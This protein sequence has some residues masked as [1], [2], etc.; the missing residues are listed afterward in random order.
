VIRIASCAVLVLLPACGKQEAESTTA[1]GARARPV[2][3]TTFYPTAYFARRIGGDHVEVECPVP[4][5]EYPTFWLPSPEVIAAYQAADLVI[6]NGATYE[7]WAKAV[8]LPLAKVVETAKPFDAE[9]LRFK[10]AIV[11]SHGPHGKHSHTGVDGHT[12]M[13]PIQAKMQAGEIRKALGRLLPEA[14][15]DFQKGYEALAADL[16]GLDAGLRALGK[17]AQGLALFASH[18]AYNYLARRY[19]WTV[20]NFGLD[21]AGK[22]TQEQFAKI[23]A[24]LAVQPAQAM[25]WEAD[26]LPETAARLHKELGLTSITFSPCELL[27][28]KE[29][30]EGLDYLAVMQA[31]VKRLKPAF[32]K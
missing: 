14:D 16:D 11:H 18:P 25:L 9:L 15:A 28:A 31:N 10:N 23:K 22:L 24:K 32:G 12:W 20:V 7:K 1:A 17:P 19:G 21:P 4:E 3:Y 6:L 5:G 13:D 27:S 8:S 29:R 2:V 26:P 30:E